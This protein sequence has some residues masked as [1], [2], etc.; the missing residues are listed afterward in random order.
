[1]LEPIFFDH[2]ATTPIS[3][4][5]K[6]RWMELLE[7]CG[8][9]ASS[10]HAGGR[11]PKQWIRQT[12]QALAKFLNVNPLELIFTSGASEA[13]NTVIHSWLQAMRQSPRK[14]ILTTSVEHPSIMEA[15][16][17]ANQ[18]GD[19]NWKQIP[20]CRHQGFN[21]LVFEQLLDETVFG[22]SIMQVNNE[23][24]YLFPIQD[25]AQKVHANQSYL[26]SDVT[27]AFG[28][29]EIPVKVCDYISFSA[30]KAYALKGCGVLWV[31]KDVPY[32]NLIWGGAQERF[33][34]AGTE[35]TLSIAA[36][37]LALPEL[38]AESQQRVTNLRDYFEEQIMQKISDVSITHGQLKRNGN[39]SHLMIPN[40]D[41]ESLLMSLDLKGYAVSTGAAC[42]SGSSEPSPVLLALGFSK[43]EAQCSLRVS[44]G[45]YN[46]QAEVDLFVEALA[47]TVKHL[48]KIKFQGGLHDRQ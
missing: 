32:S 48:R 26:H 37:G 6:T 38:T 17:Q 27:Q 34:R 36:L 40:V 8:G 9:N 24:G 25:I 46:H 14:T 33:R 18:R 13:N 22:V 47:S 44:F 30:H 5:I 4:Q 29:L 3:S 28:K 12:R 2:N 15:L 10:V 35:N 19:C 45:I 23:T 43:E 1:M 7:D 20:V 21:W 42:S 16:Y 41:G 11:K 31:K 39:T